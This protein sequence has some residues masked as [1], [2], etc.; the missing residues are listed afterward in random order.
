VPPSSAAEA[1]PPEPETTSAVY[2]H[3]MS[4]E[5]ATISPATSVL[6]QPDMV[7]IYN[8]LQPVASY[9]RKDVFSC[10]KTETSP[11]LA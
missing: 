8:G 2:V 5:V 3:F 11:T 7:I 6:V 10:S 4:G 1:L 9:P